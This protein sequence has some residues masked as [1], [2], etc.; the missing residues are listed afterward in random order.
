MDIETF[1]SLLD[2]LGANFADWPVDKA[3][4]AKKLLLRSAEARQ[5]HE[6]LRKLEYLLEASRPEVSPLRADRV[7]RGALVEIARREAN[8][9]LIERLLHLLLAPTARA[10]LAVGVTVVGFGLG[11]AIGNPDKT[12]PTFA[13]GSLMM[14]A[15]ADDVLF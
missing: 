15:S 4:D 9:T 8:P 11:M 1:Q 3:E 13:N 2:R 10:A 14:T 12:Q 6:A 5:S 7:V